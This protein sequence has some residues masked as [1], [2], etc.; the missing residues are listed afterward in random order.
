MSPAQPCVTLL[1]AVYNTREFLPRAIE[2]VMAQTMTQ[3]ELI[4]IDDASTDDS[5]SILQD[6]ARRDSR[7]RVIHLDRNS[8]PS[9]ARNAGLRQSSGKWITMLDSDDW[10]S[11]DTLELALRCEGHEVDTIMLDLVHHYPGQPVKHHYP[12]EHEGQQLT[13][14]EAFRLSLDW[15]LHG[16]MLVRRELHLRYPY[17][18]RLRWYADDD[19]SRLHLL[20][21]RLMSLSRGQYH[22]RHHTQSNTTRVSAQRFLMLEANWNMLQTLRQEGMPA[23]MLATYQQTRWYSFIAYLRLYHIHRCRFTP[24]ERQE[25][26]T[27]FRRLYPTLGRR[28]PYRLAVFRQWAGYCVRRLLGQYR[29]AGE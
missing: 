5:L 20:H 19:T 9:M 7:I 3:W 24:A 25:I 8:G 15:T 29:H 21:S 22:Y 1:M 26:E 28:A 17:D 11:P 6:Y 10:L 16:L 18:E 13:G 2:S 4:C 12:P 23:D 27:R 14:E